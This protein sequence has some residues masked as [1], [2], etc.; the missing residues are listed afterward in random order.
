MSAYFPLKSFTVDHSV[1]YARDCV[2]GFLVDPVLPQSM[3][4]ILFYNNKPENFAD[5]EHWIDL[6]FIE[7]LENR[8][9]R[10]SCLHYSSAFG[11]TVHA[12]FLDINQAVNFC[13]NLINS[14]VQS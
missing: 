10:V 2:D 12:H 5:V 6:P 3:Q 9:F 1:F 7:Y 13:K 8:L 4:Y 11:P 14:M